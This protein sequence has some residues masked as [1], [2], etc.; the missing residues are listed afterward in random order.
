[1]DMIGGQK[2]RI[3][4]SETC[5]RSESL[6]IVWHSEKSAILKHVSDWHYANFVKSRL[7]TI[8]LFITLHKK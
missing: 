8:Y 2:Y 5:T 7:T 1:M 4:E 3:L 6:R